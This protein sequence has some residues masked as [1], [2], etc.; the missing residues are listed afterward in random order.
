MMHTLD[1][2]YYVSLNC[3][4]TKVGLVVLISNFF[5]PTKLLKEI[6]PPKT[7]LTRNNLAVVK[8]FIVFISKIDLSKLIKVNPTI[9]YQLS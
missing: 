8:I 1:D 7:L 2:I 5:L 4:K 9:I 3:N 6:G